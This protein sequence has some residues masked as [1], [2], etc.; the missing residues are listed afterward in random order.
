MTIAEEEAYTTVLI[1][2][3]YGSH[4]VFLIFCLYHNFMVC[5]VLLS[6]DKPKIKTDVF[7]IDG[8]HTKVVGRKKTMEIIREKLHIKF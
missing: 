6:Y 7:V 8:K 3:S 1:R 4:K 5:C 2:V